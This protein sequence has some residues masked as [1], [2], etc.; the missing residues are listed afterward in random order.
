VDLLEPPD[1]PPTHGKEVTMNQTE[2]RLVAAS[3]RAIAK[4]GGTEQ[5]T[6]ND[7]EKLAAEFDQP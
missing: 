7:L 1:F 5:H 3:L 2:N 6:P 4:E